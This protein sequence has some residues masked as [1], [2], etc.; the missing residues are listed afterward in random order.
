MS[1]SRQAVA[2]ETRPLTPEALGAASDTSIWWLTNAG[3]MI[4]ARGT[5]LMIDPAISMSPDS[6]AVH[7]SG[8]RLLVPLP[9]RAD[10]VGR[11]EAVLYTHSDYDHFAPVTA[12]GLARTGARFAGPPLV[13]E[14]MAKLGLPG[15]RFDV[16][17]AREPFRVGEV[18]VIPTPADHPWQL[19][20]PE[21]FGRPFGPEDCCGYLVRTP[22]GTIWCP[23][24]T[25]LMS[26]H[27]LMREVDVLLLDVGHSEYHLGVE[28]A[29]ELANRLSGA[30]V[31][32]YHWGSYDAADHPA[33][34]GDPAEVRERIAGA[35]QRFHVLAPG[36]RFVVRRGAGAR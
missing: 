2:P 34:N 27:L 21:K 9:I 23:G 8:H 19:R 15:G 16:V 3:F 31:I 30:Q 24:D 12:A 36:E 11:L 5:R 14:E 29:V 26:E 7:E 32:P 6:P 18:E 17:R 20:D 35:E 13:A 4:N 1:S 10:Q 22:D 25:R 33:Y 28:S